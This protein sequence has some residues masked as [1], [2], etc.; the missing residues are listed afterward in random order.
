MPLNN[1]TTITKSYQVFFLKKSN[2]VNLTTLFKMMLFG[3]KNENFR[4]VV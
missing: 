1:N 2:Q 3:S 4:D